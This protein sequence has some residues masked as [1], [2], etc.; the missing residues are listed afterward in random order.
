MVNA[1]HLCLRTDNGGRLR[2]AICLWFEDRNTGVHGLLVIHKVVLMFLFNLFFK[3]IPRFS[4]GKSKSKATYL[5]NGRCPLLLAVVFERPPP[6]PSLLNILVYSLLPII[7]LSI[8]ILLAFWMYRH[9]K[10]PYGHV[11][12]SEV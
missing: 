12:I 1:L 4:I 3:F 8:A 7:A 10:P 6:T 2:L 9:R 5:R 11:D